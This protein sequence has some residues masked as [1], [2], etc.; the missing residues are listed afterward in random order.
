MGSNNT[1]TSNKTHKCSPCISI[2][3]F[4]LYLEPKVIV[5]DS[6]ALRTCDKLK[7]YS[8]RFNLN[9]LS[10]DSLLTLPFIRV[11]AQDWQNDFLCS[12]VSP[13]VKDPFPD[14]SNYCS[15]RHRL[16][17]VHN[18]LQQPETF[19]STVGQM[20]KALHHL[21]PVGQKGRCLVHYSECSPFRNRP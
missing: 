14:L 8:T 17:S 11:L 21:W 3:V 4:G 12:P 20:Q 5:F 15:K 6:V 19:N 18:V 1:L 10:F 13:F 7:P 9:W 16:S 2:C